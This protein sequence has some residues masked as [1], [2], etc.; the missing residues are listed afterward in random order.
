MSDRDTT[1]IVPAQIPA[2][3]PLPNST[4]HLWKFDSELLGGFYV[5]EIITAAPDRAV[6][7][8]QI[9]DVFLAWADEEISEGGY[10]PG[11]DPFDERRDSA[12][13]RMELLS[14]FADRMRAELRATGGPVCVGAPA[15][16][17]RHTG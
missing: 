10:L 2:T 11:L 15:L 12:H 7:A 14:E 1:P 9:L 8:Q 17:L 16:I 4:L 5:S 13:G 6:A 3:P